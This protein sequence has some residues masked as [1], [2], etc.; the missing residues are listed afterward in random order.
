MINIDSSLKSQILRAKEVG[1]FD[2]AFSGI[3]GRLFRLFT[4]FLERVLIDNKYIDKQSRRG[5]QFTKSKYGQTFSDIRKGAPVHVKA[6]IAYNDLLKVYGVGDKFVPIK[7]YE[8]I[9][10]VYLKA[11]PL[12]LESMAF[13]GYDDPPQIIEIEKV[14]SIGYRLKDAKVTVNQDFKYNVAGVKIEGTQGDT[15]NMPQW[16]GK[17]L[18]DSGIK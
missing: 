6:A 7:N 12:N 4:D 11:N 8:K 14:H 1:N 16:I 17:I 13:K 15:N 3:R 10:W 5:G 2:Y 9:K 18:N